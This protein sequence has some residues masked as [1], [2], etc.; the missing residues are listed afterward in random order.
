M[1]AAGFETVATSLSL[2]LYEL[3]LKKHIQDRVRKEINRKKSEYNGEITY[4]F[5]NELPYMD[6][7]IAGM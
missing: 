4:E 5:F 6:M 1:F 7:V 2:C 3:S